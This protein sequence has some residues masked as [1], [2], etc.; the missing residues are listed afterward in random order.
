MNSIT[1]DGIQMCQIRY[2]NWL[3]LAICAHIFFFFQHSVRFNKLEYN[4]I[5]VMQTIYLRLRR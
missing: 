2:A 5:F 3:W 4:L 1:D